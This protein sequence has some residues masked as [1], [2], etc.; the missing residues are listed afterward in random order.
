MKKPVQY[1]MKMVLGSLFMPAET[2]KDNLKL[3]DS[4]NVDGLEGVAFPPLGDVELHEALQMTS[5]KFIITGGISA[6]ETRDLKT[7][8]EIFHYVEDLFS[9]MRPYKNRF[10]FS[11]SCNTAID[12]GWETIKNFRDA[13]L[14]YRD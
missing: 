7:R 6:I 14:E 11:A 9:R 12:A 13:W 1:V 8:Q 4:L 10:I 2:R 5:D 3:I